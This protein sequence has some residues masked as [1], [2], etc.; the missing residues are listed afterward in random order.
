MEHNGKE[1]AD[2]VFFDLFEPQGET[3]EDSMHSDRH[4]HNKRIPERP[5][6]FLLLD[7]NLI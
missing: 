3:L 1:E 6:L 4:Y 2:E 5:R 7:F